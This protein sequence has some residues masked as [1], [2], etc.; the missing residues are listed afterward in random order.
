MR[1]PRSARH[2]SAK[3]STRSIVS[4]ALSLSKGVSLAS[5][6]RC[7]VRPTGTMETLFTPG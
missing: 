7:M 4:E 2:F 5:L 6:S 3:A 1:L